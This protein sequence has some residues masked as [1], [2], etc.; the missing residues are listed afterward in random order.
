MNAH[1]E[2]SNE[3]ITLLNG[4]I[5]ARIDDNTELMIYLELKHVI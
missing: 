5:E 2:V 4:F 1:S 3:N